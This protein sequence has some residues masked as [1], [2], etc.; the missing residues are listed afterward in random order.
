MVGCPVSRRHP[1]TCGRWWVAQQALQLCA[2]A[3]VARRVADSKQ[4][5]AQHTSQPGVI[6][7]TH[8]RQVLSQC[9]QVRA[10]RSTPAC[11]A[12]DMLPTANDS[13]GNTQHVG[14]CTTCMC[15]RQAG[16]LQGTIDCE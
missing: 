10:E 5:A 15:K 9:T 8:E 16:K 2:A 7:C 12:G 1:E 3:D 14:C 11:A 13:A 6:L 4:P